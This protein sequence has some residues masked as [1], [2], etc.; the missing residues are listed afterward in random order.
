MQPQMRPLSRI[1]IA[2]AALSLS[3]TYI[4]PVWFIFLLAPQ[5][6]EGLTMN[7]WLSR[8]SGQVEI[9]NG[10]NHYIGM[11][12]INEAMFPEF[13]YLGYIVGAFIVLGL[14]VAATGRRK[15]LFAYLI[16]LVAAA[17]AAMYDFY[18]WGYDYGHNLDPKAAIQVPGLFYQPPLLGHKKLLNFDA[19]SYPDQGGWVVIGAGLLCI[20]VWGWERFGRKGAQ[21]VKTV[22]LPRNAAAAASLLLSAGLASCKAGPEPFQLGRDACDDCKMTIADARFGAELITKKGRIYKF[23]DLHCLAHFRKANPGIAMDAQLLFSDFA[24]S[25]LIPAAASWSLSD[26]SFKSPMNSNAVSFESAAAARA[27]GKGEPVA[28]IAILDKL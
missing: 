26:P 9:I 8:L 10:L 15:H 5:Y 18:S 25:K 21:P 27:A 28:G 11:K 17:G 23:D 7:I 2:L 20:A 24:Q 16:L 6:P 3:L 1:L 19:Y 12:H 4:L 14:L 22:H 13:Q